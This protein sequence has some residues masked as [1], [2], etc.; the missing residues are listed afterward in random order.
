LDH[1]PVWGGK[2]MQAGKACACAHGGRVCHAMPAASSVLPFLQAAPS[3]GSSTRHP[4]PLPAGQRSSPFAALC[5][6]LVDCAHTCE[7]FLLLTL[8]VLTVCAPLSAHPLCAQRSHNA[9]SSACV[10]FKY[11][12]G[13][14]RM[15]A[16]DAHH[17]QNIGQAHCKMWRCR[18]ANA[19]CMHV[20]TGR[21]EGE[22]Q[23]V[24]QASSMTWMLHL[25]T[26][27][28]PTPAACP[29]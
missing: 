14:A 25:H 17:T 20:S 15:L 12:I 13:D 9:P 3:G 2:A 19:S 27:D 1:H 23:R 18:R 26:Q 8:M 7:G 4:S 21:A 16:G 6:C 24:P 10:E 5:L 11:R 28:P 29:W 22:L